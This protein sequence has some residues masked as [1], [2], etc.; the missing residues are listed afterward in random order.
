[1]YYILHSGKQCNPSFGDLIQR[2]KKH[3]RECK[4][5][6]GVDELWVSPLNKQALSEKN[7]ARDVFFSVFSAP[8]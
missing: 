3:P 5:D 7:K 1:M 8:W 2:Q 6:A 4:G